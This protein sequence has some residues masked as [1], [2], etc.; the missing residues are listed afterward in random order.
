[1]LPK[2]PNPV[3]ETITRVTAGE[4]VLLNVVALVTGQF[5]LLPLVGADYLVRV[6]VGPRFSP[7]ALLARQ[8]AR[9]LSLR[10]HLAAGP[11]KRF[12]ATIGA[13]LMIIASILALT[14]PQVGVYLVGGIM[15]L[16]PALE[17]FFGL[18]VGCK[19]FAL[20]MKLNL[21]PAAVCAECADITA[22]LQA[23]TSPAA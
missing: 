1:M 4:V 9:L 16:F 22:R 19:I 11:P 18:C 5:W 21:I 23:G 20:L 3:D 6:L 8:I 2:F 10:P 15:V 7:L 14:G 17:S 13:T 12:A